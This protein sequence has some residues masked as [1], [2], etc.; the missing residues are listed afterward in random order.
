M[1]CE[2][3]MLKMTAAQ[4]ERHVISCHTFSQINIKVFICTTDMGALNLNINLYEPIV[5]FNQCTWE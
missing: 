4:L 5:L 3:H 1:L 2:T